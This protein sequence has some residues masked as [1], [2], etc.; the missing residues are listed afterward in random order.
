[1]ELPDELQGVEEA[2]LRLQL[3]TV[4]TWDSDFF[5]LKEEDRKNSSSSFTVCFLPCFDRLFEVGGLESISEQ[6][7]CTSV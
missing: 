3:L 5:S 6:P 4:K 7:L 1:L 2:R